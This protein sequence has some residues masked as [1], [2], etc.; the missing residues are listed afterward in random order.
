MSEDVEC[1]LPWQ[2]TPKPFT[3]WVDR[4]LLIRRF[5]KQFGKTLEESSDNLEYNHLK[6][7][8][9]YTKY[10][11]KKQAELLKLPEFQPIKEHEE[12]RKKWINWYNSQP[13]VIVYEEQAKQYEEEFGKMTSFCKSGLNKP[14]TI[15]EVFYPSLKRTQKLV[16]GHVNKFGNTMMDCECNDL[17]IEEQKGQFDV[18][19]GYPFLL[20]TDAIILRYA[21][22]EL[23]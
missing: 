9:K 19:V 20:P 10:G 15:I 7:I 1:N 22:L 2:V 3:A 14:G 12:F 4:D 23:E 16:I 6:L 21:K 13:E 18:E 11:E 17:S 8:K 5:R